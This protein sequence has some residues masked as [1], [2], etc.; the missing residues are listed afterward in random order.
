MV[1]G[2]CPDFWITPPKM[3]VSNSQYSLLEQLPGDILKGLGAD[4]KGMMVTWPFCISVRLPNQITVSK[5][6]PLITLDPFKS[7]IKQVCPL[8]PTWLTKI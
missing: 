8:L 4:D 3:N 2:V 5:S 1:L 6:L 7:Q